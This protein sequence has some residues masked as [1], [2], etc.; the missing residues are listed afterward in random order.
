[1]NFIS[2]VACLS[3]ISSIERSNSS[4]VIGSTCCPW[5]DGAKKPPSTSLITEL[6]VNVNTAIIAIVGQNYGGRNF[7]RVYET[8]NKGLK[9]GIIL[10]LS[11]P[12]MN[13][14]KNW[15][16]LSIGFSGQ[17]DCM[18]IVLFHIFSN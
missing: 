11:P 5:F 12:V 18:V 2:S 1:M 14:F 3:V 9:V 15:L 7:K 10:C 17:L 4:T 13:I 8:F 6:P 16:I